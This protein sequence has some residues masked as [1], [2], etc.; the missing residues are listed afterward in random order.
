[1]RRRAA[2]VP[3]LARLALLAAIL[4]AVGAARP[5][6]A[7]DLLVRSPRDTKPVFG[8]VQVELE[9]LSTSA[10]TTVEVIVDGRLAALLTGPPWRT[11]VDVGQ[12]NRAHSF[13]F[14]ARDPGG[15]EVVATVTTPALAVDLTLDVALQQ[16]FVTVTRR[17]QRVLD[18]GRQ[19]FSVVDEGDEQTL[20]T[21]ERGDVPLTAVLLLDTSTS[22][23]G[24]P[25]RMAIRGAQ[26]FVGGMREL[27]LA[28]LTLFSDREL[29]STP[30]TGD[31][32]VI[33]G[34]LA[35]VEAD[36]GTALNDHLYLALQRLATRQ[37]RRVVILLSDGIDIHSLLET[38]EVRWAARRS[39]A[40]LYWIRLPAVT[41]PSSAWRDRG[42]HAA[43]VAELER[44]VEESGGRIVP[45]GAIDQI[46]GAFGEVLAELRDQ[47]VLGYYPTDDQNDGSW[48][49]VEVR[50]RDATLQVRTRDGYLDL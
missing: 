32:A 43:E 45:V 47:Y 6:A 9:V 11:V 8:A 28:M 3:P 17:G 27:D 29:A 15:E 30:F 20:V 12:D 5:A 50:L 25:L 18:L 44:T 1:M 33:S 21:F 19:S 42:A 14:K 37:G 2:A 41:Q 16:L 34:A 7:L 36:G 39:Q 31:A 13:T 23:R 24:E 35:G 48:H 46:A 4:G 10:T 49:R 26:R 22:M 40:L 38:D